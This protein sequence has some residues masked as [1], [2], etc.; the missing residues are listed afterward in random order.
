MSAMVTQEQTGGQADQLND[1]PDTL[2]ER[3]RRQTYN[4]KYKR[5]VLESARRATESQCLN[6]SPH[7]AHPLRRGASPWQ[8]ERMPDAGQL[9]QQARHLATELLSSLE[10]RWAHVQHVARRTDELASGLEDNERDVVAAA[11][12]LHDIGHAPDLALNGF[13]ALDGA[14]HLARLGWPSVVCALVAFHTGA[15]FEAEERGMSDALS[16]FERPPDHLLDVL[17][18]ADLTVGPEGHR[19]D[20][21]DRIAEILDRYG[22]EDPVHRA[23]RRSAPELLAAVTRSERRAN[24]AG[25]A[26]RR[27][28]M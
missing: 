9:A 5:D 19:V 6:P 25:A 13:H 21:A 15:A 22:A 17:T 26:G 12:W 27:Q 14:E 18:A 8:A 23:V 10:P 24:L 20:P 16:R 11:A 3:A 2:P 7:V 1:V 4:A 28:P